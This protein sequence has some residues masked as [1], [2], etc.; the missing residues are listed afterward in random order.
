[1]HRTCLVI[2]LLWMGPALAV[3]AHPALSTHVQHRVLLTVGPSNIDVTFELS[4]VGSTALDERRRMD[5]NADGVLSDAE[6]T[7][8]VADF[9]ALSTPPRLF[10]DGEDL[11]LI[12]LYDP[13]L[14]FSGDSEGA[15]PP[16]T[17]R[18]H[19]FARTPTRLKAGSVLEIRDPYRPEAPALSRLEA[20]GTDGIEV[21]EIHP[22]PPERPT[23]SEAVR[24]VH[25]QCVARPQGTAETIRGE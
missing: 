11:R 1:M 5:A 3:R 10:V 16:Q 7:A 8:Y 12:S 9:V 18:L 25:A 4:F 19:F 22:K 24:S 2:A 13:A 14:H 23:G 20:T 15:A 17:L 6:T 21:R